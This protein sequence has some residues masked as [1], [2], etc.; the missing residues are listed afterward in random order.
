MSEK[1]LLI[2]GAGG[3][4]EVVGETA[5]ESGQWSKIAY[6]D[7]G[8]RGAHIV[9]KCVDYARLQAEYPEAIAAFGDNGLRLAWHKK[10]LAAGYR[11]PAVVH[12]TAIISPSVQ[13]GAGC[14]VL[15]GALISTRS[16]L[17]GACLVNT[18][19]LVDHHCT[20]AEGVHVN[21]H[22]TLKAWCMLPEGRRTEAADMLEPERRAIDGVNNEN[23]LDALHAFKLAEMAAYVKPFGAGHINDTYA[24][25]VQE[26][27]GEALG[28]VLQKL[29]TNVFKKPREVM[30]NIFGVTEYLRSQI[31]ARGGDAD[32]ETLNYLKTKTG[33][34][35]YEDDNGDPWRCYNFIENSVCFEQVTK[36][37]DFYEAGKS[38]GNFLCLLQDY[39]ADTLHDTIPLFHDTRSRLADFERAAERDI[40]SRAALCTDEIAFVRRRAQ[41]CAVLM[42]LLENGTL[43]LRVTHNDTKLNNIL[44]DEKTGKPLCV[45][46]LDTIMPGLALNDFGDAIRF[47]A[48]T[49]AE[50]E[51]DLLQV[52][53]DVNLFEQFT[54]G[55]LEAA[56]QTLTDAEKKYL[57]WGA[58]IITLECGMRFLTDYLQ[59]DTYFRTEYPTHNL[60]RCRTQ[61]KLVQDMEQ[62]WSRLQDIVAKYK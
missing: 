33:D 6:L 46:D 39:P 43:P 41:D 61:F 10:L 15:H 8:K 21:L 5:L 16:V 24:V 59:G 18:G 25:Y 30:E 11:V 31:L 50:D 2:I 13:L 29:N 4:G 36:P 48:S 32:R 9:G 22:T 7:D 35:V 17:G 49:A 51:Q 3:L 60:V 26:N 1:T 44:F 58:K 57:P 14:I 45:I 53:L 37:E 56:G 40:N 62:N 54:K 55:Y 19:A 20:L 12:P 47:G 42:D 38:F 28:Y 23:L 27:G 52:H 34:T